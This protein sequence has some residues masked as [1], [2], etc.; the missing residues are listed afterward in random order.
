MQKI[1]L[2]FA[3]C[4]L[5]LAFGA[6]AQTLWKWRDAA[7]QL[8][9]SDTAP[10]AG[11]PAKN[12]ISGPGGGGALPTALTASSVTTT[13]TTTTPSSTAPAAQGAAS[14]PETAL[15]KKKKAADKE[16]AD[17]EQADRAALEASNA[18]IRK[19][20]CARAQSALASVQSGQRI[21]RTNANGEREILDDAGRAVELKH[22]QDGIASNCGP[23]PAS[24]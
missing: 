21:A 9:I 11:I 2:P 4:L 6:Q 18:A 23:A 24:R 15:D 13:S 8:H 12:I 1:A 20:N 19:D 10:P 14:G 16:R 5:A 22:A 3:A 17:K 7:G